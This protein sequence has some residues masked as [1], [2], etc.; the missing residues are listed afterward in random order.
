MMDPKEREQIITTFEKVFKDIGYNNPQKTY[1]TVIEDRG[2][3]ITFSAL[4]QRAPIEEKR[5]WNTDSD[6]R[7]EIKAAMAKYL[8]NFEMVMA[9]MTSIDV[10]KKGIDKYFAIEQIIKIL[11]LSKEEI[12]FIGDAFSK[13]GND[14]VVKRTGVEIRKVSGPEETKKIIRE[15][16]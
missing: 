11:N 7:K 12:V 9:G 10:I 8:P 15:W 3:Q 6:R 1:G 16:L 13:E 4:G 5:K 2:S 14:Y